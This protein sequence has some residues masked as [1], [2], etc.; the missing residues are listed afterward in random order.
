M[1][2]FSSEPK[3]TARRTKIIGKFFYRRP[4][5]LFL[6]VG[7]ISNLIISYL[8]PLGEAAALKSPLSLSMRY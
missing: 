4:V 6:R 7:Q 5:L 8:I 1:K 3:N 2:F